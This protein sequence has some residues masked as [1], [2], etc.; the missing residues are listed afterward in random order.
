MKA[1]KD[2]CFEF[3]DFVGW[4]CLW[5]INIFKKW[6]VESKREIV[7]EIKKDKKRNDMSKLINKATD[8]RN[9]ENSLG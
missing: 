3:T 7:K 8:E 4:I 1:P 2:I 5:R 6:K 9:K